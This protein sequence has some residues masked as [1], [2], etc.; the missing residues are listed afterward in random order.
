[1]EQLF[2][3]TGSSIQKASEFVEQ[4]SSGFADFEIEMVLN[5]YICKKNIRM[6]YLTN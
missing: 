4:L 5:A 3:K 1:M 2:A 6:Y